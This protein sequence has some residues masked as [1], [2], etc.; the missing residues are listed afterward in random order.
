MI[1]LEPASLADVRAVFTHPAVWPHIHDDGAPAVEDFAPAESPLIHY[2]AVRRDGALV[3]C[4][5][6]YPLNDASWELHT[7]LLPEGRGDIVPV[8][9][10]LFAW[11]RGNTRATALVTWVPACNL[12][13]AAAAEKASFTLQCR[14]PRA[15]RKGGVLHDLILYGA[16]VC[17][18]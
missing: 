16:S 14:L 18:V 2:L 4:L 15:Y 8:A 3:G 13:A 11:L 9:E 12:P 17:P 10:A 6:V 7:C 1:A 5:M